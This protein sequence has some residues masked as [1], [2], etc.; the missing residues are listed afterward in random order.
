MKYRIFSNTDLKV[1]VVGFGA[2]QAGMKSWGKNYTKDDVVMALNKA[3]EMGVNF[4]DT[5]EIYGG[6][7]SERLIG[8][9]VGFGVFSMI[10]V[11]DGFR[12]IISGS[13]LGA[14][15]GVETTLIWLIKFLVG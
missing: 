1:S 2:W 11:G 13:V 5:A 8:V 7:Y 15:V 10:G 14:G 4:I 9:V 3:I 12:I 6:G